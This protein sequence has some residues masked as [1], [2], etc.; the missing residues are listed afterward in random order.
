LRIPTAALMTA[1]SPL[2]LGL[3]LAMSS[4]TAV[5]SQAVNLGGG[6][7]NILA[8]GRTKTTISASGNVTEIRTETVSQGT[9]FNSFSDFQQAAGTQVDLYV[10]DGAGNLV[11]IVR[12]GPVVIDG[13]LNSYKNG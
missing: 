10:P 6:V 7:N 1:V 13:L 8:D 12:N 3:V 5:Q 2:A 9:G 4:T 11:N